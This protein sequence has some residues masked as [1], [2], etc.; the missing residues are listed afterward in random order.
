VVREVFGR[1]PSGV[2]HSAEAVARGAAIQGAQLL[3]GA[4]SS[5]LLVDVAPFT[6]G[7]EAADGS[8][9]QLVARNTTIPCQRR[10]EFTTAKANQSGVSVRVLQS[11]TGESRNRLLAQLDLDGL[12]PEPAGAPRIEVCFEMDHNGIVW[13][14]AKDQGS[15]RKK[16]IRLAGG[17]RLSPTEADDLRRKA[18]RHGAH[19]SGMEA[20]RKRARVCLDWFE[21]HL[22]DRPADLD[23][24]GAARMRVLA[25]EVR[26]LMEGDDPAKLDG[27]VT[28][29]E[30]AVEA[31]TDW[32]SQREAR[33]RASAEVDLE[34]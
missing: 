10:E 5:L 15:G 17:R 19:Q 27:A 30:L 2:A 29:M 11:V 25:E 24:A 18:E 14:S 23:T 4:D 21:S 34:L 6:L 28:A 1:E 8:F 20:V 16:S 31:M 32:V 22:R 13:V 7:V 33:P 12:R 9:V 26:R 3:L